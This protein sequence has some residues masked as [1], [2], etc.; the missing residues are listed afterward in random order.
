MIVFGGRL[1]FFAFQNLQLKQAR[2][3]ASPDDTACPG[4]QNHAPAEIVVYAGL[5]AHEAC[6]TGWPGVRPRSN[7]LWPIA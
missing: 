7:T 4:R 2:D 5:V 1:V 6:P 3:Q